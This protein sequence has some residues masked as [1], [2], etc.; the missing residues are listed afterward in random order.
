MIKRELN[1]LNFNISAVC[2][3]HCNMVFPVYQLTFFLKEVVG[4]LNFSMK[5]KIIDSNVWC[6]HKFLIVTK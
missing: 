4:G 5:C 2:Y 6:S 3:V 1:V